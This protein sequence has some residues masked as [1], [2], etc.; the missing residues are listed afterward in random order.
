MGTI[1]GIGAGT[2]SSSETIIGV[3]GVGAGV[4]VLSGVRMNDD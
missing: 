2:E 1:I 4:G 3:I